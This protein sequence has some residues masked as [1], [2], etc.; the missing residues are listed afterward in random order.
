MAG[1]GGV[2]SMTNTA[3]G[4]L[5]LSIL[6]NG[7]TIMGVPSEIQLIVQGLVLIGALLLS[8]ERSKI[9]IIK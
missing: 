9:G 7:M 6:L 4:A 5:I 3:V 2:G 1:L 8:L